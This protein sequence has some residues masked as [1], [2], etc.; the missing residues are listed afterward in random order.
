MSEKMFL[1]RRTSR[2]KRLKN[3]LKKIYEYDVVFY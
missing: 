3:E 2:T 1:V